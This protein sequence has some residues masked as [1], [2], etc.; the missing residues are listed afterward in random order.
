MFWDW[1]GV[2]NNFSL[3]NHFNFGWILFEIAKF[4]VF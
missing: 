4:V 1:V 2:R 3:Q